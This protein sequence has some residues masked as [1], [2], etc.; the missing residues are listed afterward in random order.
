[1][2]FYH[3]LSYVFVFRSSEF[4]ELNK[5]IPN[6]VKTSFWKYL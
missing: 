3:N 4:Y 5:N 2:I 1:M 6:Y